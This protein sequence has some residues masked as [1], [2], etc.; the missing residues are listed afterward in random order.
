[1]LHRQ[2]L[3]YAHVTIKTKGSLCTPRI[4]L[5][6]FHLVTIP[7][8][9]ETSTTTTIPSSRIPS[10][11]PLFWWR[12]KYITSADIT[13][14]IVLL[15]TIYIGAPV[16]STTCTTNQYN[17]TWNVIVYAYPEPELQL[18]TYE[19]CSQLVSFLGQESTLHGWI[20]YHFS[21]LGGREVQIM[22]KV[23]HVKTLLY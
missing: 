4:V 7:W 23:R 9:Q 2:D 8:I 10:L 6:P 5:H 12:S 14:V 22:E 21:Q 17:C 11:P 13:R 20:E 3:E 18:T 15:W 16:Y 1:M 19:C